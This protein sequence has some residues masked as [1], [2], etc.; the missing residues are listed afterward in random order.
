MSDAADPDRD[1]GFLAA[2]YALGVLPT[3]DRR[4]AERLMREDDTF[5]RDVADWEGRF[6]PLASAID[7]VAPP[8]HLWSAIEA[9]LPRG[10]Y[11][12]A[13]PPAGARTLGRRVAA[14]WQWLALG[15]SG[16]ALASLAGL[17][18]IANAPAP[19]M[20]TASIAAA[21]GLPLFTAVIDPA[22]G[23]ATLVP[24]RMEAGEGR[25]PELWF[26]PAGGIP[27]SMGVLD[28]ASPQR[29]DLSG[30][31]MGDMDMGARQDATL[32][33]S[34]EPAGGSPT[35]QPTGPVVGQ[36]ALHSI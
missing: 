29:I 18:V 31:H 21:D 7:P 3:R 17:A 19:V 32:A 10:A 24:V 23:Q 1:E 26:I 11:A 25:V 16:V 30:G 27:I 6:A 5:A 12:R 14:I 15:A 35:G 13:V 28:P 22:S 20:M 36:G 9:E 4:L 34:L 2:E 33:V 8:T